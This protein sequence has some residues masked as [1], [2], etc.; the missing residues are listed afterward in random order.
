MTEERQKTTGKKI[1]SSTLQPSHSTL[2]NINELPLITLFKNS[3]KDQVIV[4]KS[5]I[6]FI[7]PW[8]II[9]LV[10]NLIIKIN[11]TIPN[12]NQTTEKINS[13]FEELTSF[14]SIGRH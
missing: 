2:S 4:D 7:W 5:D 8:N 10:T 14:L 13:F 1:L 6:F 12:Q 9:T 11:S 3:S